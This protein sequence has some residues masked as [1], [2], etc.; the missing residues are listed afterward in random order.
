MDFLLPNLK[1]L[2]END[3]EYNISI[4]KLSNLGGLKSS[5]QLKFHLVSGDFFLMSHRGNPRKFKTLDALFAF[6]SSDC[7]NVNEIYWQTENMN[8]LIKRIRV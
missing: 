2:N 8:Y 3:V 1:L 5:W 4:C 6:I 7:A